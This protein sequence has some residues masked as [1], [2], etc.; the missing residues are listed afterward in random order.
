M[1]YEDKFLHRDDPGAS[2]SRYCGFL[3]LSMEDFSHIQQQLLTE[4]IERLFHSTTYKEMLPGGLPRD[5]DDFR[6]SVPLRRYADYKAYL[7]DETCKLMVESQYHWV[8]T[9][10]SRGTFKRVPWTTRFNELMVRDIIA[11]LILSSATEAG[12]VQVATGCRAMHLLPERPFASAEIAQGLQ[13]RLTFQPLP[14]LELSETLTFSKKLDTAVSMGLKGNVDF[15]VAMTSSLL[16][17]GPTFE[18]V[19]NKTRRSPK[20]L[21][22]VHPLVAWRLLNSRNRKQIL[23]KDAWKVKGI[24][25]WGADSTALENTI[26]KQWGKKPIQLYGSSEGGIMAIQ[27]WHRGPMALLPDSVFFEFIPEEHVSENNPKTI[28]INEVQEGKAYELVLTQFYGMPL[29]RYRQGDMVK[30][31]NF[32]N[33]ANKLGVPRMQFI[34]RADDTLDLFGIARLNTLVV[35]ETLN[36][37]GLNNSEWCLMKEYESEKAILRFYIEL[38]NTSQLVEL[39]K[40]INKALKSV[41]RHWAE[42][43]FTMAYNPIRVTMV[44]KGAFQLVNFS[45]NGHEPAR[46]NPPVSVVEE[47]KHLCK[48]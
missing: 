14:P 25:C 37:V 6:R 19:L 30:F 5:I 42:A 43:V 20:F 16:R 23:P 27:D 17:I 21:F 34:G 46:M 2:W 36:R 38:D 7:Q 44:P 1:K 40:R 29:A 32:T 26:E 12:D 15:I 3:D 4:Q 41:D 18:K 35:S 22:S 11:C 8:H 48:V 33:N 45:R 13:D 28:L 39:D 31:T 47:L 24:V 9:S 10:T